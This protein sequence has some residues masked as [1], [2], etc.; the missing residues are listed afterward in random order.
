M[1]LRTAIQTLNTLSVLFVV[2]GVAVVAWALAWP[3][4]TSASLSGTGGASTAVPLTGTNRVPPLKSFEAVW[5]LNL[6]TPLYDNAAP[7]RVQ[8]R[9]VFPARLMGTIL[10]PDNSQAMFATASGVEFKRI[11]DTIADAQVVEIGAD[12][13]TVLFQ[14]DRLT[15]RADE[16]GGR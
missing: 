6:R 11:G 15:L 8:A 2:G 5:E 12:S 7:T 4:E 9:A 10:E 3:Y 16:R 1:N 13:V 14:G